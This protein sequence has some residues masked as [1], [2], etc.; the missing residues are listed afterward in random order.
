LFLLVIVVLVVLFGL[1]QSRTQLNTPTALSTS[2]EAAE[3]VPPEAAADIA[4]GPADPPRQNAPEPGPTDDD[5]LHAT[6]PKQDDEW[7]VLRVRLVC[8]VE[9]ALAGD[10]I[11]GVM[12]MVTWPGPDHEAH[13]GGVSYP[14]IPINITIEDGEMTGNLFLP[15][16][17]SSD[18]PVRHVGKLTISGFAPTEFSFLTFGIGADAECT[19]TVQLDSASNGVIGNVSLSDGTPVSGAIVAGC[20]TQTVSGSDGDYFLLP[21]S[22]D[23]CTLRARHA[24]GSSTQSAPQEIDLSVTEDLVADFVI[25]IPDHPTPGVTLTRGENADGESEVLAQS[26]SP[27]DPWAKYLINEAVI[28]RVGDVPASTMSDEELWRAMETLDQVIHVQQQFDTE[29]GERLLVNHE[30]TEL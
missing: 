23:T 28:M 12:N 21:R 16:L 17:K 20:N 25:E 26:Q 6:Q 7:E 8:E 22:E 19:E 18:T 27:D 15:A 14:A 11:Q 24:P 30:V 9:P 3:V 13:E 4:T 5:A 2:T 1:Y 10:T 29:A